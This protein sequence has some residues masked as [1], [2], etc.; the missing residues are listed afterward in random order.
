MKKKPFSSRIASMRWRLILV[1][2]AILLVCQLISVFWLWHESEEQIGFLVDKTLSAHS[3]NIKISKEIREAIASLSIPSLVMIIAAL[4]LCFQAVN[5]ITRPLS[6]L[7]KELR[8]RTAENLE[9]LPQPGNIREIAA[10]TQTIN[11]LFLRLNETLQRD[12]QFTADVAHELR[13]PLSGIRLHLELH[14]KRHHIDCR[15]LIKRI[16]KMS[17]TVEQ[18]LL[19]AR[20]GQEF[21]AGHYKAV[22][23]QND[24]ISPIQDEFSEMVQAHRQTLEWRLADEEAII[25]GNAILLQLLL[26]NLVE[27]AHRYSPEQSTI[28][29]SVRT[30]PYIE[31]VVEDMGPGIDENKVGE[32]SRAFVRMDS[33]YGGIGLGLSIVT[34]IAQ[35]HGGQF[36]LVNR[37]EGPGAIASVRFPA[38]AKRAG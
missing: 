4:L 33:R 37:H 5:W 28:T 12:R 19:L 14:E 29:I 7:Q 16:D 26:H 15:P 2:G 25:R 3:Q 20:A 38:P 24:V 32:L 31:L 1:L 8:N 22:S 17:K 10:V 36:F 34:R 9:P 23:L 11:Q 27:N 30:H 21:S 35:L 6:Q 18:L 13:T